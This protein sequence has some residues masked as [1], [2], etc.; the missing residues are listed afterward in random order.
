MRIA[1]SVPTSTFNYANPSSIDIFEILR[2]QRYL[3]HRIR[4]LVEAREIEETWC[5]S[6]RK[7]WDHTTFHD[8]TIFLCLK[9]NKRFV[10]IIYII[11]LICRHNLNNPVASWIRCRT[12]ETMPELDSQRQEPISASSIGVCT[13]D[14]C[15]RRQTTSTSRLCLFSIEATRKKNRYLLLEVEVRL[16]SV[17]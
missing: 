9:K 11:I 4:L 1:N 5:S 17:T 6:G 13:F 14:V 12:A 7:N 3:P 16:F 10:H 2:R 8:I 15:R